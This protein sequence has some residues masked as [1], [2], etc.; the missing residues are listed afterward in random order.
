MNVAVPLTCA[1]VAIEETILLCGIHVVSMD[2]GG[3]APF[4][5]VERTRALRIEAVGPAVAVV[6]FAVGALRRARYAIGRR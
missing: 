6:I 5:I 3:K 2:P 4:I 1:A